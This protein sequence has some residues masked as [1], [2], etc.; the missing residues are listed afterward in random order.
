MKLAAMVVMVAVGTGAC[1]AEGGR[2]KAQR[3]TVCMSHDPG[4]PA[5]WPAE[6]MAS[7]IFSAIGVKLEWNDGPCPAAPNTLRISVVDQPAKGQPAGALAYA[8]PY[9]GAHVVVFYEPIERMQCGCMQ[10][11]PAYVLVHE[12]THILEGIARHS[13]SGIMKAHW[14]DADYDKIRGR[15]L[16]FAPEDVDLIHRGLDVRADSVAAKA[17]VLVAAR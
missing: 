11:L 5:T 16:V 13:P 14:D 6:S 1:A 4:V 2:A 10:Q 7:R 3:V 9:E 12:I 17:P 15:S 8:L